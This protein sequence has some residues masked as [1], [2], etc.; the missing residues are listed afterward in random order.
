[1]SPQAKSGPG[2]EVEAPPARAVVAP[3]AGWLVPGAGHLML[4]RTGRAAFFFVIVLLTAWIGWQLEGKLFVPVGDQPLSMLGTIGS[5]AMGIPYFV[6][7]YVME[8]QGNLA[9]ARYEYGSAFLLT[10]G[11]MNF[12]VVLDAWDI[13]RGAKD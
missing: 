10:A 12:M 8:Y 11:L 1:M 6:L 4:G 5:M 7:R 9:S 3:L 2:D 13:G